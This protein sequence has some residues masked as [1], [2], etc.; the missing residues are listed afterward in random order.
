[1]T[2]AGDARLPGDFSTVN[3][4]THGLATLADTAGGWRE[5]DREIHRA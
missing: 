2:S 3:R 5:G 4:S 1:M